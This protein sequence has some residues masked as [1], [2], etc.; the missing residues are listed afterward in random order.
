MLRVP[1][2]AGRPYAAPLTLIAV[3][4]ASVSLVALITYAVGWLPLY[5]LVDALGAPSLAALLAVGVIARRVDERVFLG[6]LIA[7]IWLGFVATIAYDLIRYLIRAAGLI[8]FDPFM[9]H[10]IFGRL[11]TGYAETTTVAIV[12]GWAYHYWNGIGLGLMYTLVAGNARWTY[13]VVWAVFLEVCWLLTLPSA[14][15]L[16]LSVAFV[17]VSLI[18][19]LAYGSTLGSLAQRFVKC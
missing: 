18:G 8:S 10:A 7:G 2:L 4:S 19:H 15:Q 13:A 12:A 1:A 17:A 16:K 5:F 3:A 6:R 11:I 9:T 14:F